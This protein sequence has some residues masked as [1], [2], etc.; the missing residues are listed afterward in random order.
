MKLDTYEKKFT[1]L[2][3]ALTFI[4]GVT[5]TVWG[6]LLI[7]SYIW[8]ILFYLGTLSFISHKITQKG[9]SKTPL[10]AQ[11][12]FMLSS[13]LKIILSGIILFLYFYFIKNEMVTFLINFFILYFVFSFF[14]IKTLLLSLHPN[15]NG[16]THRDEIK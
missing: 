6:S 15:S 12:Y 1:L 13:S 14:E 7:N 4:I 9:F 11:N 10:D 2:I 5:E 8:H 3:I 16:D